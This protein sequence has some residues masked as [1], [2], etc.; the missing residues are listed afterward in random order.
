MVLDAS[1]LVLLVLTPERWR[2]P[3]E[4]LEDPAFRRCVPALCDVELT[5]ALRGGLLRGALEVGRAREALGDYL[6][7]PLHRFD[8]RPLLPRALALRDFLTA[9]DACYAALAELLEAPLYTADRRLARALR[10]RDLVHVRE[11]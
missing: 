10:E 9:Y 11:V 1:A 2:G 3:P 5:S 6:A 4:I 7:L 8:H